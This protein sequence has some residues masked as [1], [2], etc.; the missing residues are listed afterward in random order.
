MT[1][2]PIVLPEP[3]GQIPVLVPTLPDTDALIPYLRRIDASN[4][5]SNHGPLWREFR[6]LFTARLAERRP[7]RERPR[8]LHRQRH[9]RNR[10]VAAL[11]CA[12]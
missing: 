9:H 5:Y 4:W 8:H 10:T 6:D 2:D 1:R 3:R 11:P 7:Q 12:A